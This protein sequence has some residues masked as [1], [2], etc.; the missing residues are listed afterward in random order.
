MC[1]SLPP[2]N[3]DFSPLQGLGGLRGAPRRRARAHVQERQQLE[4]AKRNAVAQ[5]DF[6]EAGRLKKRLKVLRRLVGGCP[7]RHPSGARVAPERRSSD[8][9]AV[10]CHCGATAAVPERRQDTL[11]L[12]A[13]A[14]LL[15]E[16][17]PLSWSLQSPSSSSSANYG[18]ADS[19]EDQDDEDEVKTATIT[20]R[21][22]IV[23]TTTKSTRR[24][25]TT[26]AT[27]MTPSRRT[28]TTTMRR[29]RGE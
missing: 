6:A 7:A 11:A 24:T 26:M 14:G 16:Y 19:D 8:A 17:W 13:P 28:L 21:T 3:T 1:M 10:P 22:A 5:E 15:S 25:T 12:V 18:E 9:M 2:P 23:R 29:R 20:T 4:A 27:T